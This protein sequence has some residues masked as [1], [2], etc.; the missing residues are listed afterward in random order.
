M[1]QPTGSSKPYYTIDNTN[2]DSIA[3]VYIS[4]LNTQNAVRKW[5]SDGGWTLNTYSDDI[6][7]YEGDTSS[8]YIKGNARVLY[9]TSETWKNQRWDVIK[10]SIRLD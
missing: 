2:I 7:E 4:S 10:A 6:T 9:N 3:V 8:L 1:M 5:F